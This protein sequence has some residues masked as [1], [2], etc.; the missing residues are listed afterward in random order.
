M[1]ND[2]NQDYKEI[3]QFL[4][5]EKPKQEA[6]LSLFEFLKEKIPFEKIICCKV[7]RKSKIV[8]MFVEYSLTEKFI[9][10]SYKIDRLTPIEILKER[11]DG[12]FKNLFVSNHKDNEITFFDQLHFPVESFINFIFHITEDLSEYMFFS[13]FSPNENCFTDE[14]IKILLLVRPFLENLLLEHYNNNPEPHSFLASKIALPVSHEEQLRACPDLQTVMSKIET[15][16]DYDMTTLI[17]GESGVGKELVASTI[18]LLSPRRTKPFIEVNCGAIPES[19]LESELF[20]FE[21]GAFTGA[22]L[23]KKGFFEQAN[24]GTIFLDEIGEMSL[25]AQARLLR[26]LEN[27]KIQKIGSEHMI[28]LDVRVIAATNKNLMEL[29]K[30]GKFREDLY[31]RLKRFHIPVKPLSERKRDIK[32]LAQ[33][34]YSSTIEKYQL[35]NPPI[36]SSKTIKKLTMTDWPGNIRQ[37]K[38]SIEEAIF[39]A[40]SERKKEL[41]FSFSEQISLEASS[42]KRK[43]LTEHEIKQALKASAGKIEGKNGAA[44]LLQVNPATLRS[45]MKVFEIPF[46]KDKSTSN[47]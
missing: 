10:F 27:K 21:K 26:V 39:T 14:H 2:L 30:S 9:G 15:I 35:K 46:K 1:K 32:F 11:Y 29:V 6:I 47:V 12:D 23:T 3:I 43:T 33:Y 40:I 7:N 20:G 13:C 19:L 4:I 45:R 5:E 41:E 25:H 36:L 8:N 37:L 38:Y 34:F 44:E 18:H 28:A 24:K 22:I 17:T 31:Y 16:A 42:P